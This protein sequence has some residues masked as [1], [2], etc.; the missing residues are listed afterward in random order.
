[1]TKYY[2][3]KEG[4]F[5]RRHRRLRMGFGGWGCGWSALDPLPAAQFWPHIGQQSPQRP[6]RG[7]LVSGC[8]PQF[9]AERMMVWCTS[10]HFNC[11]TYIFIK[12]SIFK[13]AMFLF[14][15]DMHC[16]HTKIFQRKSLMLWHF[17]VCTGSRGLYTP[18]WDK[19]ICDFMSFLC[20]WTCSLN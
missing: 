15:F 20:S 5:G 17:G 7:R 18:W 8:F 11:L 9:E 19:M 1:M 13:L 12:L 16:T 3:K 6:Y 4:A 2:Y 14:S 10:L